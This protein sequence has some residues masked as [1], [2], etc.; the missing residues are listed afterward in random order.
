MRHRKKTVKLGRTT[1]QREA[2][3]SG[4]VCGLIRDKRIVTTVVKAKVA[5]C[6]ADRMVTLGKRGT[7][8]SRA[9]ALSILRRKSAVSEL[10]GTI[11]PAF[12]DRKGGYTRVLKLASRP[13]TTQRWRCWNG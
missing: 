5:R 3:M 7:V 6:V 11:A 13:V 2:L 9:R 12:A 10:F 1:E 4:L 8:A